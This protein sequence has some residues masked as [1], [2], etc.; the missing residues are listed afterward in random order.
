MKFIKPEVT[1]QFFSHPH[2]GK[3][4]MALISCKLFKSSVVQKISNLYC[5]SCTVLAHNFSTVKKSRTEPVTKDE[6]EITKSVFIS[7]SNNIFTNLAMEDWIYQNMDFNK[8]H[9]LF[10][11]RNAPC[12]VIGRHQ[13]PWLE[14]NMKYLG[15]KGIDIAR[16]NSG[17]TLI[18]CSLV[19]F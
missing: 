16:R 2:C 18:F 15:E 1:V 4:T 10:I 6:S 17:G 7:Q 11:W 3:S 12:V 8:H 13:N 9:V 14:A 19:F 5:S